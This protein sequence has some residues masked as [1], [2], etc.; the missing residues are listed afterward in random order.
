MAILEVFDRKYELI[1]GTSEKF[2]DFTPADKY[3]ASISRMGVSRTNIPTAIDGQRGYYDYRTIPSNAVKMTELHFEA[4]I[5]GTNKGSGSKNSGAVVKIYNASTDT[6]AKMQQKDAILILKAGYASDAEL[7]TIFTGQ[8]QS[9]STKRPN[10]DSITEVICGD[11]YTVKKNARLTLSFPPKTTYEGIFISLAGGFSALGIPLGGLRLKP[12]RTMITESGYTVDGFIRDELDRLCEALDYTW[13]ISLSKLYIQP[14][15]MTIA[16][17]FVT[18]DNQYQVKSINKMSDQT[19]A[20]SGSNA[21]GVGGVKII[22]VLDGRYTLDKF[23][24]ISFGEYK[25]LY[26]ITSVSHKLSYEGT[27]WDTIIETETVGGGGASNG[28]GVLI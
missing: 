1:V 21:D 19:S 12:V 7:P 28:I 10:Q 27:A 26:K 3:V 5:S 8:I 15:G 18:L 24:K 23:I 2:K 14:K 25:G 13:Y 6:I 16:T 22:S 11:G 9:V 4:S 20:L 17:T